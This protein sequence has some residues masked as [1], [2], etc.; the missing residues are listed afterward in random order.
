MTSQVGNRKRERQ[1]EAEE[2]C[3]RRTQVEKFNKDKH[4]HKIKNVKVAVKKKR[5]ESE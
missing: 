4:K 5:V 2:L 3:K 1:G